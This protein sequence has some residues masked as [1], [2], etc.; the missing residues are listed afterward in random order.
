MKRK[1]PKAEKAQ[2][3]DLKIHF[4]CNN[5][6]RFCVQG[7]KRHSAKA[8]STKQ[9]IEI[10]EQSGKNS[11][12]IIFTGGEPA[13]HRDFIRLV[14]AAASNSFKVIQVQTNGR[15]F[16]DRNFCEKAVAAGVT[17]ISPALHG[18]RPELHD[19]LTRAQG[20]F[21]QTVAG[22][23]NARELGIPVLTNTV[24]TKSNFR[25]LPQV[26]KLLVKLDVTQFQFAFVHPTGTAGEEFTTVV[27]RMTMASPFAHKGLD[28]GRDAGKH[29]YT[30]AIPFCFM[31]GYETHVAESIIPKT[32]IFDSELVIDD[33]GKH[34]VE[35][36]KSKGP[37]CPQCAYY[38]KCEGPWR[39]YPEKYGWDEFKPVRN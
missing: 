8:K 33:Y 22:I 16:S 1:S 27:P 34:R 5:R 20:S 24:I 39:E 3:I 19:Y 9:L 6:C 17:E 30:E 18:H 37:D 25:H 21:N 14:E 4:I 36:G 29:C 13:I 38:E 26:A 11:S 23:R 12:G 10:I 7:E 32:K 28:L 2:R 31:S 35:V 15:M